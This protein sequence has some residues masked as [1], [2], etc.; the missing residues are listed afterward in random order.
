[1]ILHIEIKGDGHNIKSNSFEKMTG[2]RYLN[3]IKKLTE[4]DIAFKLSFLPIYQIVNQRTA[5]KKQKISSCIAIL[6]LPVV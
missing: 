2:G 6:S 1:M 4:T 3:E 5:K